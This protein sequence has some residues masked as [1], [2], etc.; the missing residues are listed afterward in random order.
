MRWLDAERELD[1]KPADPTAALRA[2]RKRM[3]ELEQLIRNVRRVG[4]AT[5]DE[6]SAAVYYKTEAEC[7]V[8][9]ADMNKKGP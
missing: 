5:V 3:A 7:W 1:K 8:L 2:H 4:Q 6:V 9:Q